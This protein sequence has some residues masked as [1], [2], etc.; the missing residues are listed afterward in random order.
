MTLAVHWVVVAA[1]CTAE[2]R[3]NPAAPAGTQAAAAAAETPAL[4]EFPAGQTAPDSLL[5]SRRAAA[6]A[7]LRPGAWEPADS[8][9]PPIS[10]GAM[11]GPAPSVA[12]IIA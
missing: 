12:S 10:R 9:N 11:S 1:V 7:H 4:A 2:A 5:G 3:G 6:G 8:C